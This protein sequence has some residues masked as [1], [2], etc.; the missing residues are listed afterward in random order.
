MHCHK[1]FVIILFL[2]SLQPLGC[3]ADYLNEADAA[4]YLLQK[5]NKTKVY[6]WTIPECLSFYTQDATKQY[7]DI[8]IHELHNNKC[9]GDQGT[10]PVIDR[11]RIYRAG[12]KTH[13]VLWQDLA[14]DRFLPFKKFV[15]S[16]KN[17]LQR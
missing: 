15:E 12:D 13:K 16:R 2:A 9:S 4:S 17:K 10:F 1:R 14:I 7:F 3:H 11:F 8:S 6:D 5:I